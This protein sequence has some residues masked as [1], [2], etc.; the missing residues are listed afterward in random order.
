V[1][2]SLAYPNLIE[3]KRLVVIVDDDE[4]NNVSK[5]RGCIAAALLWC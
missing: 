3:N 2:L 1:V 4:I 5:K